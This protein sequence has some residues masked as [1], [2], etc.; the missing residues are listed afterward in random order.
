[1]AETDPYAGI[2]GVSIGGLPR[3]ADLKQ[4]K[5]VADIAQTGASAAS[6]GATAARTTALTPLEVEKLKEE[7]RKARIEADVAERTAAVPSKDAAEQARVAGDLEAAVQAINILTR[8]FNENLSKKGLISSTLE[9]FPSQAKG[10]INATSAGLADVGLSL[11]KVPGAGAQS[12]KD[13]ERFVAANQPSTSDFDATF[14]GKTY[15]LRRR[16]DAKA[17]AMG[18]PPISWVEPNDEAARQFFAIP[19]DERNKIGARAVGTFKDVPPTLLPPA[20]APSETTVTPPDLSAMNAPSATPVQPEA[21]AYGATETTTPIPA[22]MQAEM[23]AWFAE[24]PRGTV[25]LREYSDLRKALDAKYG[26]GTRDYTADPAVVKFLNAYNDPGKPVNTAIPPVTQKDTRNTAERIAGT[27][28]MNPIGT[29]VATGVSGAGLNLLDAVLPQLAQARE[30][31]P[32]AALVGDI[33][34]GIVGNAALKALG[35]RAAQELF[36]RYAPR[37]Y[38]AV[39]SSRRGV[40][41]ARNVAADVTQGAASGAAVEGDALGGAEAGLTGSLLGSGLGRVASATRQF[42]LRGIPRNEAA[43][44]LMDTYGMTDLTVGQQLGGSARALEDAATSMPF[45]GDIINARRGESVRDFNRAAFRDVAGQDVGVGTAAEA[46]LEKL[47]RGAYDAA[48]AGRQ[49]DLN[50]PTFVKA[51]QDALAVRETLT[52]EFAAK[53]D[54]AIQNSLAGTPAG[55]AGTMSGDAY[56]QAQRKLSGYKPRSGTGY[57]QD[58]RDALSGAQAALRGTVERQAPDVVPAL[59]EADTLYRGER[60][61]NEAVDR[62]RKD[63]TGLG[64]DVFTPGMLQDAV[65]QSGRKFPGQVPLSD[66]GML[67]QNVIPSRLPDSGTARRAALTALGTVGVGGAAG[68]GLGYNPEEGASLSDAA[69]GA[70]VPLAALLAAAAGGSRGGQRALGSMLFERPAASRRVAE[71]LDRYP[72]PFRVAAPAT[73]QLAM[74]ETQEA[75]QVGEVEPA[76]PAAPAAPQQAAPK[77]VTVGKRRFR[78]DPATGMAVD[79]DTDEVVDL[80]EGGAGFAR[81][82]LVYPIGMY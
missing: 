44:K 42:G 64:A 39:T 57:E 20:E 30:L 18:L 80:T 70:G 69:T 41:L 14:L 7:I 3:G 78:I 67:A 34:G 19:E 17:Q 59:R 65:Y 76:A 38:S 49:F 81:G 4:R 5:D 27:A 53:F 8:G 79:V 75:P 23:Q 52:D 60:I 63:P 9:Y 66:L 74:P 15:N 26:F 12:D 24:H 48:T 47:R 10:A 72:V 13:A 50:D 56:Q 37:A 28:V 22:E 2:P 6:S 32:G 46:A 1:M 77:I 82:G 40:P 29:A 61:L 11:F 35:S 71:L 54:R 25:G 68:A 36:G 73:T 31:N 33:G 62:A 45:I 58:F 43:Q 16:L 55:A 21:A 51:M